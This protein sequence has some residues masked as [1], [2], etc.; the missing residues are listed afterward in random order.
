MVSNCQDNVGLRTFA[1][2]YQVNSL[3]SENVKHTELCPPVILCI[4]CCLLS[5][6][7]CSG[8]GGKKKKKK[9]LQNILNSGTWLI[10]GSLW[11][12]DDGAQI[13]NMSDKILFEA[14]IL[15]GPDQR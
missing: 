9:K 4:F 10:Y 3:V 8:R 12:P 7:Q 2:F 5:V 6:V 1:A 13:P 11:K 15:K 14:K